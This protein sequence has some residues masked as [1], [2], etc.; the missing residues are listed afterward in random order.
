M[1]SRNP[2]SAMTILVSGNCSKR[3]MTIAQPTASIS[4]LSIPTHPYAARCSLSSCLI[5]LAT[6]HAL[7]ILSCSPS[8]CF[9]LYFSYPYCRH[10]SEVRTPEAP[11]HA[12]LL[13]SI[14]SEILFFWLNS[15]SDEAME[16]LISSRVSSLIAPIPNLS[17]RIAR[18]L[19]KD[20]VSIIC[21]FFPCIISSQ[22]TCRLPPPISNSKPKGFPGLSRFLQDCRANCISLRGDITSKSISSFCR[23]SSTSTWLFSARR[24][25]SV[26]TAMTLLGFHFSNFRTNPSSALTLRCM[27]SWESFPLIARFSPK[28]TGTLAASSTLKGMLRPRVCWTTT[29]R[30]EFVPRSIAAY[31][32]GICFIV[33]SL[34]ALFCHIF[35]YYGLYY[36]F[37]LFSG[38]FISLRL[39]F[40]RLVAI[41]G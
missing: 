26:A 6:W 11:T 31:L 3:H 17:L 21:G 22:A 38:G 23:I 25:D 30:H 36:L 7:S 32:L 40:L 15:F 1:P 9:L 20:R 24:N 29:I 13:L 4:A 35:S 27:D 37:C 14:A 12:I 18:P 41:R 33:F 34:Y 28:Y 19:G 39:Y 16:S 8:I 10:V 5:W 2:L